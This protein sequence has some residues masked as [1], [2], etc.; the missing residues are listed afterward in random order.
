VYGTRV[1][2]AGTVVDSAGL[3]VSHECFDQEDPAVVFDGVNFVVAWSGRTMTANDDVFCNRVTSEGTVPDTQQIAVSSQLAW[4]WYPAVCYDGSSFLVVWQDHRVT[5]DIYGARVTPDGVRLDPQGIPISTAPIDQGSVAVGRGSSN[6]LLAWTD[7]RGPGSLGIYAARVMPDGTAPDT[8]G[9]AVMTGHTAEGPAVSFDGGNFLVVWEQSGWQI[10]GARVTPDGTVLDTGGFAVSNGNHDLGADVGFDGSNYL[11]VWARGYSVA[12]KICGARVRPDGTVLD[13]LGITIA[14]GPGDRWAPKVDAGPA[15]FLVVWTD[16]RG[17]LQDIYGARV[18]AEGVV[19]DP[20][21]IAVSDVPGHEIQPDVCYDGANFQVVWHDTR[22]DSS[23]IFG[24]T[25]TPEG[26]V[27]DRGQI[28]AQ[29][30]GQIA[31]ALAHGAGSHMLLAYQSWT[32]EAGGRFYNDQRIWGKL[33]PLGGVAEELSGVPADYLLSVAPNPLTSA[34]SVMYAL[35]GSGNV[36]LRLYD[37]AGRLV[38]TLASGYHA[39][40]TY[41]LPIT[42][43]G[44][45]QK[46]AAGIYVVRLD[47]DGRRTTQK[48]VVE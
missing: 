15:G 45:E 9:I 41:S 46:L 44:L 33:G 18:T 38:S 26:A 4:Q 36:S 8:D 21:G 16:E 34:S 5:W 35:P 1:S 39:A 25:V 48:L 32:G 10:H 42:A 47:S 2:P 24:A 43:S 7:G 37:I 13:T 11:V 22:G 19:L 27:L 31:P 29:A 17:G 30:G 20:S 6:S 40:G 23:D 28:V 3:C 14:E 12:R